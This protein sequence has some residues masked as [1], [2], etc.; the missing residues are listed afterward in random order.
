[1]S[2][3]LVLLG[4]PSSLESMVVIVVMDTLVFVASHIYNI[5]LVHKIIISVSLYATFTLQNFSP[6]SSR[7][8]Y[9]G[10]SA[11]LPRYTHLWL[12]GMC[13]NVQFTSSR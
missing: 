13:T 1:M 7:F 3:F 4:K 2:T 9:L 11:V 8:P 6:N 10:G 12:S 5:L